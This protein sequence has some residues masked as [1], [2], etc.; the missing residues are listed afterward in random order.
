[1][2]SDTELKTAHEHGA[3]ALMIT[4][5]PLAFYS[6]LVVLLIGAMACAW[7][8][9]VPGIGG[10]Q[11][12]ATAARPTDVNDNPT[13]GV[14]ARSTRQAL[15]TLNALATQALLAAQTAAAGATQTS[16]AG[17]TQTVVAGPTQTA[18]AAASQTAAVATAI[19]QGPSDIPIVPGEIQIDSVDAHTL[20]YSTK[21]DWATV[22]S[23]YKSAMPKNGWTAD[24]SGSVKMTDMANLNFKKDNRTASVLI[25]KDEK[26][27]TTQLLITVD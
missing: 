9:G 7:L 14:I 22:V 19:S 23:F 6:A 16:V 3:A 13:A 8:G 27:G 11:T 12:T 26:D 10:S 5:K 15:A 25:T 24:A 20:I 21:T 4:P 2:P 17:A 1:M 18:A